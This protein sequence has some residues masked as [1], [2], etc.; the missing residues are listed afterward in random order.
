MEAL[1][2]GTVSYERGTP[3]D[4]DY[5]Y[6]DEQDQPYMQREVQRGIYNASPPRARTFPTPCGTH[7][8]PRE[9]VQMVD[10]L[11]RCAHTRV[12]TLHLEDSRACTT[13]HSQE[14]P[15]LPQHYPHHPRF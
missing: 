1:E 14:P 5:C 12:R 13:D 8:G 3:V 4:L 15:H 2:G 11:S 6:H 10:H 7:L 9:F